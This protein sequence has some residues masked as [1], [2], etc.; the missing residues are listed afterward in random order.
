MTDRPLLDSV[1]SSGATYDLLS[2]KVKNS[3]TASGA[4]ENLNIWL[5]TQ[6]EYNAIDP[7]DPATVYKISNESPSQAVYDGV[8]TIQVNGSTLGTFSANSSTNK[9]INISVPTTYTH[10]QAQA[11]TTWTITHNLG[12]KPSITVVDS[13]GEVQEAKETY[14][15]DNTVKV[16]FNSAFAGKAYLN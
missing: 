12:K 2:K 3:N 15:D 6:E 13:S 5:G 10:E 7:K 11:S 1:Q 9:T 8:L 4:Q 14:I 16:E